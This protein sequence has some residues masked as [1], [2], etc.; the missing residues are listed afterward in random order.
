MTTSSKRDNSS[1]P[2]DVQH[3]GATARMMNKFAVVMTGWIEKWRASWSAAACF[4]PELYRARLPSTQNSSH[5]LRWNI[6]SV[7]HGLA[8]W[9]YNWQSF[10]RIE[11]SS[12][13]TWP[14]KLSLPSLV[15]QVCIFLFTACGKFT[16]NDKLQATNNNLGLDEQDIVDTM[17]CNNRRIVLHWQAS[18][19][20]WKLTRNS[21]QSYSNC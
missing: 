2:N 13:N 5:F 19:R 7:S 14:K 1:V 18:N 4:C 8:S 11:P 10:C 6:C 3:R 9:G 15:I 12:T 16:T 20:R 17:N 21:T